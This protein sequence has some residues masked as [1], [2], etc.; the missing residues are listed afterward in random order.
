M[1]CKSDKVFDI[2][3]GWGIVADFIKKSKYPVKVF[4]VTGEPVQYTKCGRCY[5]DDEV[6]LL[7]H[8]EY[9]IVRD[10]KKERLEQSK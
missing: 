6:G 2:R 10:G 4:F 9:K 1:F 8:Y 5:E 3:Y 7:R